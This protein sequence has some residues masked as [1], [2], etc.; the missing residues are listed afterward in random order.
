MLTHLFFLFG[1]EAR[2]HFCLWQK[3]HEPTTSAL[4]RAGDEARLHLFS[5]QRREKIEDR[6]VCELVANLP[7]AGWI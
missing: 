5:A 3:Y 7:L 6:P 4:G 2:L 1:D